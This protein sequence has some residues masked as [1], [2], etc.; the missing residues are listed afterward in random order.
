MNKIVFFTNNIKKT[1]GSEKQLE[2]LI[3]KFTRRKLNISIYDYSNNY[4]N[5]IKRNNVDIILKNKNLK[6]YRYIIPWGGTNTKTLL[7]NFLD[8]KK[9]IFT[10][11]YG[12]RP[13]L[14]Y[15]LKE[16][17]ANLLEI[18]FLIFFTSKKY[19]INNSYFL[20]NYKPSKSLNLIYLRNDIKK[21]LKKIKNYNINGSTVFYMKC[22]NA[23]VKRI[24]LFKKIKVFIEKNYVDIE[25][26]LENENRV[27]SSKQNLLK[28]QIKDYLKNKNVIF[29]MLSDTE[30]MPNTVSEAIS[31]DMLVISRNIGDVKEVLPEENIIPE[32]FKNFILVIENLLYLNKDEW[33]RRIKKQRS[34]LSKYIENSNND[35]NKL[36]KIFFE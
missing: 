31:E 24:D 18:Y 21:R 3:D 28:P 19:L 12:S 13:A 10:F 17:I 32:N 26:I 27:L 6:E 14:H 5:W 11:R 20:K 30:G 23:S 2:K 29:L 22:R 4:P 8:R 35:F 9:I 25:F 33:N 16:I 1:G 7:N 15:G 34:L 36:V